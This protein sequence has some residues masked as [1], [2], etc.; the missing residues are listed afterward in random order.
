MP[1]KNAK[2]KE[3]LGESFFLLPQ[4]AIYRVSDE[5]LLLSDLHLGKAITFQKNGIPLSKKPEEEDLLR[6]KDLLLQTQAKK[7]FFLGDLFHSRINSSFQQVLELIANFKNISFTL[8]LG[9]HDRYSRGKYDLPSN[10]NEVQAWEDDLFCYHHEPIETKKFL[11]CG[12]IHPGFVL[13]TRREKIVLPCFYLEPHFC[14]LP[15]FGS[16]TG[17]HKMKKTKHSELYL[18]SEGAIYFI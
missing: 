7:V 13:G 2:H 18:I 17:L 3:I 14:I 15:S 12:H 9:N 8:V 10:M 4:K 16:L 11:I 6:L 5:S 1:F